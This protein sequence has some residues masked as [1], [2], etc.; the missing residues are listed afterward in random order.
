MLCLERHC[1]IM[2]ISTLIISYDFKDTILKE[3]RKKCCACISVA[4]EFLADSNCFVAKDHDV[5]LQQ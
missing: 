4:E 3:W 1:S 2:A 5:S